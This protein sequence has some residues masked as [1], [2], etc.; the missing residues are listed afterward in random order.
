MLVS[1]QKMNVSTSSQFIQITIE[2]NID[3][4]MCS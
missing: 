2:L 1:L 3:S 4:D